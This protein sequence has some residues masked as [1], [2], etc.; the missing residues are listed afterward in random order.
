M[1]SKNN[2]VNHD[3]QIAHFLAGS[4]HTADGA[5][6]LLCDLREDRANA[7]ATSKA[8][9]LRNEAKRVRAIA[10]MRADDKAAAL[11][12]EADLVELDAMAATTAKN[13]A[14]C[15]AELATIQA[16]IDQLAPL[17][18]FA[19]LPDPQAHEAA[20]HDEWKLELMH[21]AENQLVTTGSI[22]PD[23]FATMRM[24]PAFKAELLPQLGT[25]RAMLAEAR[26]HDRLIERIASTKP[27]LLGA[28]P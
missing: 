12:G 20:Q 8:Y 28:T 15:E 27:L 25:L 16:C 3:F 13:I 1:N 11:E 14:A 5:Y 17:R 10:A 24:H 9:A 19:H 26:G 2:R 23:L 21:R 6:S 22:A 4:C 18:R 7:L